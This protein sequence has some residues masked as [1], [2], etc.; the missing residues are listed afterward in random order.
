[1][2]A[3]ADTELD[4]LKP[5]VEALKA[6]SAYHQ[7]RVRNTL[8]RY[9]YAGLLLY[10]PVNI[11]YAT[12]VANQQVWSLHNSARYALV[13]AD[14][15]TVMFEIPGMGEIVRN[16]Y[17]AADEIRDAINFLYALTGDRTSVFSQRWAA[18]IT[19][20]VK[21]HGGNNTQLAV[22]KLDPLGFSTLEKNGLKLCDGQQIIETAAQIKSVE[23]IQVMRYAIRVAEHAIKAMQDNL[24]PGI[25]EQELWS[26]MHKT[27][28]SLGSE[29]FET[30][31]L[32]SGPRTNPWGQECSDRI[33]EKGDFV[34]FDTDLIGSYGYCADISRTWIAGETGPTVEQRKL[35]GAAFS[36]LQRNINALQPG[37]EFREYAELC[38]DLPPEYVDQRYLVLLHGVGMRDEYPFVA[39]AQDID[40]WGVNGMF[41]EGM[42]V[43]VESYIGETRG[44]EG[45]KL[46]EQVLIT[47]T[48]IE[49]LSSYPYE[50]SL[51]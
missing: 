32:A 6:L 25:S 40:K 21:Q 51:L 47:G 24:S 49:R 37:M 26:H 27:A 18:E 2:A 20:L 19:D 3:M 17:V 43:C 46:E 39:F 34:A 42:T 9:D 4:V 28:V 38:S 5:D 15:Y 35:Y 1:M 45:V 7:Y 30:R 33:I 31:L 50:E 11:R 10:D 13:F 41:E 36:N 12:G 44:K 16:P 23:E 14:G 48:G 22:D 29:W 8:Q